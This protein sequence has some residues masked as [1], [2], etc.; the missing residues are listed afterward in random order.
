LIFGLYRHVRVKLGG[1]AYDFDRSSLMFSEVVE[2]E[3]VTGL[4]FG[5]WQADLG[6][7][8][9]RAIAGLLHVLRK[10][11]GVPSDFAALDF[12]ADDLDVIPLREDGTEMTAAQVAEDVQRRVAEAREGPTVPGDSPPGPGPAEITPGTSPGSPNGTESARGNGTGSPGPILT[13]S[14]ATPTPG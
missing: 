10:R 11:A 14:A 6:R 8:S 3:N 1:E 4:S 13:S 7:Y 2:I 9:I 12:A 5:E